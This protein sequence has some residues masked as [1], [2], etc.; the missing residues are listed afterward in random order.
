MNLRGTCVRTA[1]GNIFFS[2][3]GA[4]LYSAIARN[5]VRCSSTEE[6]GSDG[7]PV[8]TYERASG[9]LPIFVI[10]GGGVLCFGFGFCRRPTAHIEYS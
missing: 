7:P 1:Q 8:G 5:Q 3:G 9:Q 2:K 6:Q 10:G 4:I